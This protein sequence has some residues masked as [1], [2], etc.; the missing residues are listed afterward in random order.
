MI[1]HTLLS[2]FQVLV[3]G[4][5]PKDPKQAYGRIRHNKLVYFNGS[6]SELKGRLAMVKIGQ[7]NAFSLFGELVEV[8]PV[9]SGAE[10]LGRRREI[11]LSAEE[12]QEQLT[13]V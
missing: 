11:E 9:G 13:L 4:N 1:F 12:T 8:L 5:N 3:E 10:G 2:H 7:C 6:G